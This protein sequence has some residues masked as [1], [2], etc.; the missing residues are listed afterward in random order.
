M[1]SSIKK[2]IPN[3]VTC[4]N[5]M[6]GCIGIYYA[7]LGEFNIVFFCVLA[8]GLFDLF[9]GLIARL[10]NVSSP[11]GRELDSLADVISFGFLPGVIY[12]YLL[13]NAFPDITWVPFLGFIITI[14]SALR[15]AKFNL[16]E[17]QSSDFIGLNTPMNT[18]Y[19]LS[20]PFI[21]ASGQFPL[22]GEIFGNPYFLI[23]SI[24]VT[25]YLLNSEILLFSMKFK[26]WAWAQNKYR[27]SF[28]IASAILLATLQ[29][30]ALP[31]ILVFYFAFSGLHFRKIV[32]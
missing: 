31:L 20:L 23:A 30:H 13:R 19:V 14:F 15:L 3:A 22:F 32:S 9:D 1:A 25:S 6:S 4:L 5:L 17:R 11:I 7:F 12:F 28:L 2:H 29:L 8:S 10:L 21:V 16:D 27:Y 18:F 24:L 26:S